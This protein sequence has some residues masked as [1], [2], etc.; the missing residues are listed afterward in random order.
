M[1]WQNLFAQN[2]AGR[3]VQITHS[4]IGVAFPAQ[5][6]ECNPVRFVHNDMISSASA[7]SIG[8]PEVPTC[9]FGRQ[10]QPRSKMTGRRANEPT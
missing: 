8:F 1:R 9:R 5:N 7:I 4:D 6:L 2:N 10:L 3:Q